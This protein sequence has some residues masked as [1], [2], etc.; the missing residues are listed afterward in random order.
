MQTLNNWPVNGS[1]PSTVSGTGTTA[2]Y[3]PFPSSNFTAGAGST[4]N[5]SSAAG[6][7]LVPGQN[8]VN[9]Q[10]FRIYASGSIKTAGTP[11]PSILIELVANTGS[12]TTPIYTVIASSGTNTLAL[13]DGVY[14][15][16]SI[17]AD[18]NGDSD[19][20]ILQGRYAAVLD[21]TTENSTPKA[22]DNALTGLVFGPSA[23]VTQD[24]RHAETGG[25]SV[26]G[27]LVRVTF[28][29]SNA[30]NIANMYRFALE[31]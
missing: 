16:W 18:V 26:F 7:L 27:L 10:L 4:P 25:N 28:G 29:T 6:Q 24:Q 13:T 21:N 5:A 19:S 1:F 23:T 22:L 14:F 2:K 12:V 17:T 15:P 3:F 20:G 11:S 31:S 9:G 30:A 8:A